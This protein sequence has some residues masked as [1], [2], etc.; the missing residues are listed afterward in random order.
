M[1]ETILLLVILGLLVKVC[2]LQMELEEV[3]R[4]SGGYPRSSPLNS[5]PGSGSLGAE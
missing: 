4:N 3:R 5:P 2:L 1:Y